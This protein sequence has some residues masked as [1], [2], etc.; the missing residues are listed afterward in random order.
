MSSQTLAATAITERSLTAPGPHLLLFDG[1][2]PLCHRAVRFLLAIDRRRRVCFAPLQ[3]QTA[4]RVA[5]R[6]HFSLDL[7]T[8]VYVRNLC[9]SDERLYFESNAVLRAVADSGGLWGFLATLLRIIPL[10]LRNFAYRFIA[11]RRFRWFGR[12]DSCP[13]PKPEDRARFLP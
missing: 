4:K 2:C 5:E 12:Y 7:T 6:H 3:G 1:V 11:S 9:Q 8:A 10:P 13:L